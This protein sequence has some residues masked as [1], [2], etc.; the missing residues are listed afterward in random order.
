[1]GDNGILSLFAIPPTTDPIS[2][3]FHRCWVEGDQAVPAT[4]GD[5]EL[6]G[7]VNRH[8]MVRVVQ[9]QAA[10]ISGPALVKLVW[11][12]WPSVSPRRF[13]LTFEPGAAEVVLD[14]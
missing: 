9:K 10:Y 11:S 7:G 12:G 1:V 13:R 8:P 5:G 3:P 2:L 6:V 14:V 4:T